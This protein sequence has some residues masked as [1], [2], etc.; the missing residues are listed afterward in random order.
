MKRGEKMYNDDYDD[1][2]EQM[3]A[4]YEELEVPPLTPKQLRLLRNHW[5]KNFRRAKKISWLFENE[6]W[7]LQLKSTESINFEM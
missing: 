1:E 7:K 6:E 2:Y 3:R 5:E 4:F